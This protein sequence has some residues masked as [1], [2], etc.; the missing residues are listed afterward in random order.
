LGFS[1]LYPSIISLGT[2]N[3]ENVS[4]SLMTFIM[5]SGSIGGIVYSPISGWINN[6][7]G[8]TTTIGLGVVTTLIMLSISIFIKYKNTK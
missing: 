3:I 4:P 8:I 6:G 5:M 7:Y 1:S 2:E